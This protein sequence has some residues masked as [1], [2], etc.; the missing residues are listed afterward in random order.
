MLEVDVDA[1]MAAEL[2]DYFS[3]YVPGYKFMPAY[4]NKVWDGK[5]K[6][7][8]RMTGELAAGLYVYL[9]KFASER[10]YSVDTEESDQYGFPVPGSQ[11]PDLSQ[12][13]ADA[14][15]PFQPR[16]YQYDAIE[17]ALTR[18][19]AILLSPTGSGKSFIAYLLIKY[20]LS[21]HNEKILLIVPTTSLVE[22]MYADF[23]DY[24]M[25]ADQ[26]VHKIYSGKDKDT[27][28]RII[29]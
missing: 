24:G 21:N 18:S 5:I 11:P 14:T 22:Q 17:T 25:D 15:L 13:L 16:D 6:L 23:V 20:F 29:I 2:S 9:L 3:F 12:I 4:K 26:W 27:N 19:R 1:G 10:S 8:N 7:F 28:K